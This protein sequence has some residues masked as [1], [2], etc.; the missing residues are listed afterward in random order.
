MPLKFGIGFSFPSMAQGGALVHVYLDGSVLLSHGG[1][2][3]GQGLH[4][5]MLQ[6]ASRVLKIPI[7]RIYISET[8]TDKV[9]NTSK[10]AASASSDLY[11]MAV[12]VIYY[13]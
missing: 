2:E 5:K 6:V 4:T 12:M 7:S 13:W 3:I 1:V 11:G 9:P 8:N 10:T